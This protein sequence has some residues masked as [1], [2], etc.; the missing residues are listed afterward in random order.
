MSRK[1]KFRN[2]EAVYF[3]SFTTINWIDVFT[4]SEYKHIIVDSLNHCIEK[5]GLIVYAW[6]IMSNHVH[7]V[8][9]SKGMALDDILRDM[10]KFTASEIIKAISNNLQESRKEWMLWMFERAGKKNPNNTRYQF[11]QQHNQPIELTRHAFGIDAA[12]DY[13]HENPV[14]AGFVD[15]AENYPFSSAVDFVGR[16]G[17]V[18]I[19]PCW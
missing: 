3:V 15:R 5:K 7:L 8:I 16:K 18:N 1:Y 2:P 9:E 14:K 13:I 17:L 6:V 19:V 10:K 12:I 4:R 11:W